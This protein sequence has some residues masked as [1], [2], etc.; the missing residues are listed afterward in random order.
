MTFIIRRVVF[1]ALL[2]WTLPA[3]SPSIAASVD[4]GEEGVRTLARYLRVDTTNPPGNEDR[5]VEFFSEIF[6]QEGLKYEVLESAPH[7]GNIWARI[8]GGNEPALVLLHHTDVVPSDARFWDE[9]PFS[10]KIRDGK[11]YGRGALDDKGLGILQLEAFL[12]LA[13]SGKPLRRDVIFMAT[14]DEEAG[15]A[16][17]AGY[18]VKQRPDIFEGVGFLLNEGGGGTIRK[19]RNVFNVEVTQK[20]PL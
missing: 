4:Y 19:D 15:G 17:G 5:A 6:E 3:S 12:S 9:A 1:F 10:G 18:L 13:R 7:R 14:A 8:K 20:T 16:F 11:L 2:I